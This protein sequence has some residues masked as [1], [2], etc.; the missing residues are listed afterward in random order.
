MRSQNYRRAL[1]DLVAAML[2]LAARLHRWTGERDDC[3]NSS[4]PHTLVS[5]QACVHRRIS[6]GYSDKTRVRERSLDRHVR[7]H[8]SLRSMIC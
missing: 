2:L 3:S 1:M 7:E 6:I 4:L 5:P 8:T